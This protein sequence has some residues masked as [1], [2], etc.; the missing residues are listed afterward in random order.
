M[1]SLYLKLFFYFKS[2]TIL[3]T[4]PSIF[5]FL[6]L[7]INSASA[8]D[9]PP[10]AS[11]VPPLVFSNSPYYQG[12]GS[13][14]I[15]EETKK[16]FAPPPLASEISKRI[17]KMLD[18]RS[19]S[20]G[21]ISPNGKQLFFNWTVT[22]TSQVWRQDG[23][24]TFPV[25]MSGGEEKTWVA[26]ISPNGKWI[27]VGRDQN[28]EE[29]P[30]LY[31]QSVEGGPL[32]AILHQPKIQC[33][34]EGISADSKWV[35]Y[36][37]NDIR[38]DS[39]AIYRFD[40][41][42]KKRELLFSQDGL[43]SISDFDK[44]GNFIFTK[45]VGAKWR[46][47]YLWNLKEKQLTPL[48]GIREK[49]EYTIKFS[50]HPAEY[51]VKTNRFS[52]FRRLYRYRYLKPRQ[53]LRPNKSLPTKLGSNTSINTGEWISISNPLLKMDVE[54]FSIDQARKRIYYHLN[55]GGYTRLIVLDAKNFTPL[56]F[57]EF[58]DADHLIV[59]DISPDGNLVTLGVES[60]RQPKNSYVYDWSKRKLVRWV[61]PSAPEVDL[62]K[63]VA[64]KIEYYP[65]RDG[66]KIP[67][68]VRRPDNC[69][70]THLNT[71]CP[72]I[73]HF[74][75]GPESQTTP[76]FSPLSQ[77]YIDAGFILVEPNVRGSDGYGKSWLHADDGVKRLKV[78][79]D[80]EDCALFIKKNWQL[81]GKIPKI[82]VLGGSYGGY[83]A[84]IA[85]GM[86]AG[87]YD[88][89]VAIVGMSNL[90]TFLKNTAPYRRKLRISEYGDPEKDN[91]SLIKLSP[92]T[93]VDKIKD[94]LLIMQGVNDPRVPVG[95]AI[96]I[97]E[98][99]KNKG[100]DSELILF[101]D[102]GHGVSKRSNRVL[103]K[104]YTLR[105]FEKHLK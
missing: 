85:M 101:S 48:L 82:G 45:A 47:H 40:I 46:E 17:Q 80:I 5:L 12:H 33:K 58:K 74:H 92:I 39:Y 35:Y 9:S 29:N 10:A 87:S 99:L 105:F 16:K 3:L 52:E 1:N 72:V 54:S 68:L 43:W 76:G 70:S 15:S 56:K 64:A 41:T 61:K 65:A 25:Q 30:G 63:F 44:D 104:G 77:L 26:D 2:I 79:T 27:I 89:G 8:N 21:T 59:G 90:I 96:Q 73:V 91:D 28:G 66:T 71:P 81:A 88:A 100:V 36:A 23:A 83:S 86:F 94:P 98:A 20:V 53:T 102:E 7:E 55:D 19:A 60:A 51:L 22:G 97:H 18:V 93:Y 4:G 42:H 103:E 31:I 32:M 38:P 62:S 11:S 13:E 75:G 50:A 37:A 84:L 6:F 95:E 49:E 69:E 67:M 34:Y 24:N 14:S 78:I 57:P